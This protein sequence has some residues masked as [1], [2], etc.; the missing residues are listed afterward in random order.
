M[1]QDN[2]LMEK[3]VFQRI[4]VDFPVEIRQPG[5]DVVIN[6]KCRDIAAAGIGLV[7]DRQM[8]LNKNLM[9]KLQIPDE[10]QPY[11]VRARA[12]WSQ[13]IESGIWRTGLNFKDIEFFKHW[14]IFRLPGVR[15]PVF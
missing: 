1:G 14:R 12:V 7:V 8:P 11:S 15:R 9:V 4:N 3:R 6:A 5:A 2:E 13:E 10:R